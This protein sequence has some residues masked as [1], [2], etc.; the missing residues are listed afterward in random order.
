MYVFAFMV[1]VMIAVCSKEQ[2]ERDLDQLVRKEFNKRELNGSNC[3]WR[4]PYVFATD[5]QRDKIIRLTFDKKECK[6]LNVNTFDFHTTTFLSNSF[7]DSSEKYIWPD[8]IH[9]WFICID[10]VSKTILLLNLSDV[11]NPKVLKFYD[12]LSVQLVENSQTIITH[13]TSN[14]I[15]RAIVG[16]AVAGGVGAVIGGTTSK[17]ES[18]NIVSKRQIVLTIR[19]LE[20]S[21]LILPD[22]MFEET[23]RVI[24]NTFMVIIDGCKSLN[25]KKEIDFSVSAEIANLQRLLEDQVI[26]KEEFNVLKQRIIN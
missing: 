15:G 25:D 10:D 13:S 5:L 8:G 18:S 2:K 7:Q 14:T 6:V 20:N 3:I 23:A 9:A 4:E 24:M 26:T 17:A 11:N 16:A 1:I 19:D 21:T 12:I 22:I